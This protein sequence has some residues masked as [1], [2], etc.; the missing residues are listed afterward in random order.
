MTAAARKPA[1]QPIAEG[2]SRRQFGT[3]SFGLERSRHPGGVVK[4]SNVRGDWG[5]HRHTVV[6]VAFGGETPYLSPTSGVPNG[7]TVSPQA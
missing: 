2:R 1:S 3:Y 5:D 4:V 7:T 6:I